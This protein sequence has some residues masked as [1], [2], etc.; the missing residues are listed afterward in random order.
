MGTSITKTLSQLLPPLHFNPFFSFPTSPSP[1]SIKTFPP[2][3]TISSINKKLISTL[4]TYNCTFPFNNICITGSFVDWCTSFPMNPNNTN[5]SLY[6]ITLDLP[7]GE[8]FI[9]FIVDG[10]CKLN[11]H[12]PIKYDHKGKPCNVITIDEQGYKEQLKETLV[13]L[14]GNV[15][16]KEIRRL[17]RSRLLINENCSF[18][19]YSNELL[20]CNCGHLCMEVKR[21]WNVEEEKVR[22]ICLRESHKGKNVVF[23]YYYYNPS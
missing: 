7:Q 17:K 11:R 15:F 9:K 1:P 6:E 19:E 21:R 4:I 16:V 13:P 10:K 20:K 12:L 14:E 22:N 5:K 18:G 23:S 8:H 3:P 2:F